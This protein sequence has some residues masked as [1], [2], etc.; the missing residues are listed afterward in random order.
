[1]TAL[2]QLNTALPMNQI[3]RVISNVDW[4]A[5]LLANRDGGEPQAGGGGQYIVMDGEMWPSGMWGLR[6]CPEGRR[7]LLG[8]WRADMNIDSGR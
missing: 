6:I 5:Q 8:R 3:T 4:A 1:M 2:L 7:R